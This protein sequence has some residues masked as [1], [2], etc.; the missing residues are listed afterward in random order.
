MSL[1]YAQIKRE[2]QSVAATSLMPEDT[3]YS[4]T[5]YLWNYGGSYRP[6]QTTVMHELGHAM[7]LEHEDDEY[8]VMGKDYTHI[9]AHG[10][11]GTAYLG[12]RCSTRSDRAVRI[13]LGTLERSI[14]N[15]L[16]VF[17]Y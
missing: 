1:A 4:H 13:V 7:G 2:S 16:E 8:N 14:S 9:H 12:R 3:P 15:A 5:L 10:G 11:F 17:W 6:Y